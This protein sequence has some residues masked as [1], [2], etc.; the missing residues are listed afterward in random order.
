M[1]EPMRCRLCKKRI[2]PTEGLEGKDYPSHCP[3]CP[4]RDTQFAGGKRITFL[5]PMD[6]VDRVKYLKPSHVDSNNF[7]I[8]TN[9]DKG[10]LHGLRISAW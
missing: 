7:P 8:L 6:G 3:W 5:E 4:A 10:F 2:W 1:M 9:L